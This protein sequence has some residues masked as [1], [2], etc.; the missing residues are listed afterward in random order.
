MVSLEPYTPP[1]WAAHLP[2]PPTQRL[3]LAVTPSPLHPWNLPGLPP[4]LEVF[5]KRDD[6][7]GMQLSGNKVRPHARGGPWHGVVVRR[8][9]GPCAGPRSTRRWPSQV[10]KLEFLL[11]RAKAAGHDSVITIGGIQVRA[12]EGAHRVPRATTARQRTRHA[13]LPEAHRPAAQGA[14]ALLP[15]CMPRRGGV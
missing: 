1:A 7:T 12:L 14:C 3:R 4:G 11:A 13:P 2:N 15:G 6:L 10:R 8:S 5:V 9:K